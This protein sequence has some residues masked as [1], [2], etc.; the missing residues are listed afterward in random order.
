MGRTTLTGRDPSRRASR[1]SWDQP[2]QVGDSRQGVVPQ[3][4]RVT[5]DVGFAQP[6]E[7]RRAPIDR[8]DELAQIDEHPALCRP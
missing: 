1:P 3:R 5:G 7:P 8:R 6:L 2:L 4:R